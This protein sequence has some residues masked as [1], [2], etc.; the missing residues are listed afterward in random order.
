MPTNVDNFD[1]FPF[2]WSDPSTFYYFQVLNRKK[3]SGNNKVRCI[4]SYF[5]DTKDFFDKKKEDMKLMADTF[6]CRVY[7]HPARRSKFKVG[8]ELL[9]YVAECFNKDTLDR[10]WRSYETVAGRNQWV[11][12]RWIV[13]VDSKD[14]DVLQDTFRHIL[15]LRPHPDPRHVHPTVN[16]YHII[17]D[18][19]FDLSSYKLQWDVHKNNPTL[20]Y[21]GACSKAGEVPLQGN[22]E[23]FDSLLLQDGS[24]SDNEND[25]QT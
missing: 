22:C 3:Q 20:L 16:G 12:K 13:D 21:G 14:E 17:Y 8:L 5:I 2:D 25:D 7:V 24:L 10:L 6:W 11:E 15:G 19:G 1:S 18:R 9:A 23:G 4:K